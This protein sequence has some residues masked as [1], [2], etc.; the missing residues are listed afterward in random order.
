MAQFPA[1]PQEH[2]LSQSGAQLIAIFGQTSVGIVQTDLEGRFVLANNSYCAL[3]GRS[4]EELSELRMQD[5]TH[6]DDRPANELQFER[7]VSQGR[8][9]IVEKRYLR[10][11]GSP[12]WVRN[13]VSL[14]RD[15]KGEPSHVVAFVLDITAQKLLEQDRQRLLDRERATHQELADIGRRK[16]E[17]LAM[18]GHEL[19]NPLSDIVS[20]VQVLEV[21]GCPGPTVAE[22]NGII[23]R[24]SQHMTRLI[25]DLLDISRISCGK[26]VLQMERL[27]LVL[28]A[29]NAVADHRHHFGAN[30]LTLVE[31][32]PDAPVW[33]IGDITR[34]TQV[35]T[36]LLH[37]AMKFNN[38]GGT[39]HV[40]VSR[41][42][43]WVVLSVR[44]TGIGMKSTDLMAM[45]EPFRQAESSAVRSKGGLGLGLALSLR[46]IE[47]HGGTITA[48]SP[49]VGQGSAFNF[50]LPLD[51]AAP[52]DNL[53]GTT[54]E[55][56][57]LVQRILIVDDRR[58]AR[59]TL[60][61]LLQRMGQHV[62][63]AET[64]AAALELAS[65]FGPEIMICDIGLP[66][67]DGYAVARAIRGDPA[68]CDIVLVALTG[69]GQPED[70][71]RARQAGFDRH[72]TKPVSHDQ[73]MEMV[74][75]APRRRL[76]QVRDTR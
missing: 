9:F 23:Q 67:M 35:I 38:R 56:T 22:M 12:M 71:K 62:A 61:V 27:D 52:L 75:S 32:M 28:L 48:S 7:L 4:A 24:Q 63:E 11:D 60:T 57:P 41:S 45:F 47:K 19:R 34:L 72:L 58:D 20:A 16:D 46:I 33:V 65:T 18:L 53:P 15:A 36:N 76:R 39:I 73:L 30:R 59:L 66:D 43:H 50:E 6:P 37:N 49:G 68:L 14:I 29:R 44:D 8:D 54:A 1:M 17:F 74:L 21:P 69:Y 10:G 40:S 13:S 51:G 25:D 26:I 5:I 31:E 64:G 55:V 42:E 70:L 3:V 2:S